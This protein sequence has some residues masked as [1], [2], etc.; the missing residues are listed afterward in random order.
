MHRE[1][2]I[3]RVLDNH[4]SRTQLPATAGR[5][6]SEA[7]DGGLNPTRGNGEELRLPHTDECLLESHVASI[8]GLRA[9]A[10]ALFVVAVHL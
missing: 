4:A 1:H 10:T 9:P 7:N 3:A 2:A 5:R 8:A 6:E